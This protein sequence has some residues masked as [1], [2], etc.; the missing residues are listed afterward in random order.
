MDASFLPSQ[1][2]ILRLRKP[3]SAHTIVTNHSRLNLFLGL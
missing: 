1:S 3:N 2:I